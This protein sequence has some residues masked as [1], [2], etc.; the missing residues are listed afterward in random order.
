MYLSQIMFNG[1]DRKAHRVLASDYHMH[2]ALMK[3]FPQWRSE[4]RNESRILFRI[5][6]PKENSAWI[7]VLVQS[8]VKPDWEEL[9]ARYGKAAR[10][11]TC[12]YY[13]T[14]SS[15]DR[16]RFRLRANPTVTRQAKRFALIGE[17]DQL[18]WLQRQASKKGFLIHRCTVIDEGVSHSFKEAE[19]GKHKMSLRTV[20]YDGILE[21]VDSTEFTKTLRSG[22]GPAKGLGCGMLSLAPA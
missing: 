9:L 20:R 15:G 21:V 19:K 13:L 11:K 5:E 14:S 17:V 2:A 7:Q 8:P 12:D 3:A 16:F 1:L 10:P 6:P 4:D 18:A 22:I